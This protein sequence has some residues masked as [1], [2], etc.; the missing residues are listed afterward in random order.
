MNNKL[1]FQVIGEIFESQDES[2]EAV[3][4]N[5]SNEIWMQIWTQV[6]NI[7]RDRTIDTYLIID[8]IDNKR[9]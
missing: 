3:S 7:I 8:E 1:Q 9:Y 6:R 2:Y 4:C 5:S